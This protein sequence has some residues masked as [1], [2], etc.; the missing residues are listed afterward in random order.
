MKKY[1]RYESILRM[2]E[3]AN[4]CECSFDNLTKVRL[5]NFVDYMLEKVSNNSARQYAA[6]FKAVLN[7]YSEEEDLPRDYA[8]I[9]TLR[10]EKSSEVY[11]TDEDL[12]KLKAYRCCS[13]T[14]ITVLNQFLIGVYSGARHSDYITFDES[15]VSEG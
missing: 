6:K 8:K 2:F 5:Q 12:E 14:E 7:I 15:N 3:E 4:N 11:L 13:D 9:L 1:P 10:E